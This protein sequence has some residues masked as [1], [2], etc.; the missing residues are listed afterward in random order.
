MAW[1]LVFLIPI[2]TIWYVYLLLPWRYGVLLMTN[3]IRSAWGGPTPSLWLYCVYDVK[4]M[5][6]L[7]EKLSPLY[8]QPTV[9]TCIVYTAL[10]C[11]IN[12]PLHMLSRSLQVIYTIITCMWCQVT[13]LCRWWWMATTAVLRVAAASGQTPTSIMV[14][15]SPLSS[16][17]AQWSA[18]HMGTVFYLRTH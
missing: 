15:Y 18:F 6:T 17:C 8:M 14:D 1:W 2:N 16:V 5:I 7:D 10:L 13:W 3:V 12:R 11:C 9:Y 4:L